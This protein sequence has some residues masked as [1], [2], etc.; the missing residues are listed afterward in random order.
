MG[1]HGAR[2]AY[3]IALGPPL[4]HHPALRELPNPSAFLRL[5]DCTEAPPAAHQGDR[6]HMRVALADGTLLEVRAREGVLYDGFLS[7][8]PRREAD[9]LIHPYLAPIAALIHRWGGVPALHGA[10]VVTDNR[11]LAL[12]GDR[13][14]G[15]TTTAAA[16]VHRRGWTLLS[17]DL[18]VVER[19]EALAGPTSLDL[20][21]SGAELLGLTGEI[22]RN[23]ERVRR[24]EH[25]GP[26]LS[27]KLIACVHL[28][29]GS[30]NTLT[31]MPM[32]DRLGRLAQQLYWPSLPGSPHDLLRLAS[33]PHFLLQRVGGAA[34][35]AATESLLT[36]VA[37]MCGNNE[38][39]RQ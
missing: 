31:S 19:G 9:D 16:M 7:G 32:Q 3:G 14:A 17:D 1:A 22:V 13:E 12:I 39:W 11:A 25:D 8:G 36:E 18:L 23:S 26:N 21:P 33:L 4:G 34:G 10:A 6:R 5:N 2:G 38:R 29:F 28:E 24:L 20:R 37:S 35:L 27:A 30:R 15:K